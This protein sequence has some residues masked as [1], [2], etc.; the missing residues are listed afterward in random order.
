VS[1]L[2]QT[3]LG[4]R[5]CMGLYAEPQTSAHAQPCHAHSG[6]HLLKHYDWKT[7]SRCGRPA[8]GVHKV[9]TVPA[10]HIRGGAALLPYRTH[11]WHKCCLPPHCLLS[12]CT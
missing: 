12:Q 4:V 1:R 6:L 2:L 3:P 5:M 8:A 7:R 10:R 9:R 11:T